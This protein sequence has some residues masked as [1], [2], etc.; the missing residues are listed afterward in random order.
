VR[1]IAP[2]ASYLFKHALIRDAAY[3]ALLK[4]RRKD[5]HRLVGRAIDEQFTA[6]REAHPEVL[7]RHWTEAGETEAAI[8]QWSRAGETAEARN[9][10][11]EALESYQRALALLMLLPASPERDLRELKFSQSVVR[12]LQLT[13]G[14]SAPETIEATERTEALAEQ[15]GNLKQLF[16]LVMSRGT[17]AFF[18]GDLLAAATLADQ[19]LELALR[20]GGP[21]GLA[22]AHSLHIIIRYFRGDRAGVEKH[23]T[24]ARKLF[25]EPGL[26][27]SEV[28]GIAF[29]HASY[30]AWMLGRADVARE[31][32]ARM[33][34]T[35][36]QSNPNELAWLG[37]NGA[38][39][40]VYMRDYEQAETLAARALELAEK[41]QYPQVAALSPCV[42]GLAVAQL[43]RASEGVALIRQGL[44]RS[45][46]IGSRVGICGW[47][48]WLAAAQEREGAI[49]EALVTLEQALQANPDELV[50]RP[51]ALRIR[52]ELWLKQGQTELA[53]ASFREAIALAQKI[54]AKAW[55]LRA[56]MSLADML[57]K[58]GRRD[59]AREMLA[60]IYGW[61][62]EGFD[63]ADLNDAKALLDELS[64]YCS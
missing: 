18:L 48:A 49:V 11:P 37:Y 31:R 24:A 64:I 30:N 43:G 47:T 61:F 26:G 12:M 38:R 35:A 29:S 36:N 19:A 34:A 62:T 10:F 7:A 45:L 46:E 16:N 27:L 63:T 51:E 44:T 41:N 60:K 9:A 17:A 56:T 50:Y 22:I 3:E 23:S 20:E 39:L 21:E 15:S 53:E 54:G 4:T 33:V 14:Y 32:T 5:L 25:D 52:G 1:G 42:L 6:L 2:E 57:A 55:E 8:A 40:R 28:A 59:E 58:E 13:R